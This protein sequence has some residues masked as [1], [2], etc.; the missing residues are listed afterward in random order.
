L[1][2]KN[3]SIHPSIHPC[4]PI[5]CS[6]YHSNMLN[7]NHRILCIFVKYLEFYCFVCVLCL[8]Q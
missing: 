1:I 6:P 5:A 8:L 7:R 4:I 2:F 3:V